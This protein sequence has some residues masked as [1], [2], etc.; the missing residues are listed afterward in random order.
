MS[1]A[2]RADVVVD[3]GDLDCGSGLLLILRNAFEPLPAG[4]VLELVSREIS[5]KEDLPAWCRMVGHELLAVRPGAGRDTHYFVGK[6]AADEALARDLATARDF[7]WRV[8][9][10]WSGALKT[11]VFARNHAFDVGQPASFET[12]DEAPAAIEM[13]L[14]AL[15]GCLVNGFAWRASKR[16]LELRGAELALSARLENVLFFLGVDASGHPGLAEV[17][18][19]LYL[20]ADLSQDLFDEL[21]RETLARSPV[22]QSLL[23][24]APIRIDLK[25]AT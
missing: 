15:A 12:A 3:G 20:D 2:P 19:T 4:G 17:T 11:R 21:W 13:L 6:R 23:R 9:A 16:G 1:A 14:G 10:G 8:R 5:V 22:A 18:G 7:R 24:G 25:L